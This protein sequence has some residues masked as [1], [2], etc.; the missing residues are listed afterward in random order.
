[1]AWLR[2][3]TLAHCSQEWLRESFVG[4][5]EFLQVLRKPNP[6]CMPVL[7][8]CL[9]FY[10]MWKH[11]FLI[12]LQLVCSKRVIRNTSP[13]PLKLRITDFR[14]RDFTR[15]VYLTNCWPTKIPLMRERLC[16]YAICIL[17]YPNLQQKA[18][19]LVPALKLLTD[20]IWCITRKPQKWDI[21]R[22]GVPVDI[23]SVVLV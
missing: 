6:V 8:C 23:P 2:R 13:S 17:K 21:P 18:E 14:R 19:W 12:L 20:E 16:L 9:L 5:V 10:G 1:M 11:L 3:F 22:C 7:I 4:G 15:E